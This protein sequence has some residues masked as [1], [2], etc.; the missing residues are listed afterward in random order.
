M[1]NIPE[2]AEID[3]L[4]QCKQVKCLFNEKQYVPMTD[5][6]QYCCTLK[7]KILRLDD[8]GRCQYQPEK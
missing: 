6:Q 2:V 5:T 7:S 1:R 8:Q 3:K 4:V